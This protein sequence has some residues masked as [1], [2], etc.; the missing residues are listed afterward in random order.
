MNPMN[1]ISGESASYYIDHGSK[2]FQMP[3]EERSLQFERLFVSD[4]D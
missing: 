1:Y 3:F 2:P 4:V